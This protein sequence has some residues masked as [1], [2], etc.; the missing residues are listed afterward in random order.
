M[1]VAV[2]YKEKLKNKN[3]DSFFRDADDQNAEEAMS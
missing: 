1:A 2:D 3:L